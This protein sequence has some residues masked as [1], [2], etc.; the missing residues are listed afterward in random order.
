MEYIR[1]PQID[2]VV[3]DDEEISLTVLNGPTA[4]YG[5]IIVSLDALGNY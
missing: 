2:G 3:I 1:D 5:I 4:S